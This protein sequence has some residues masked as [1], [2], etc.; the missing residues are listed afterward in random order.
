MTYI[1]NAI[2]L[3]STLPRDSR[4]G[5]LIAEPDEPA[6][7]GVSLEGRHLHGVR[8]LIVTDDGS[9]YRSSV[10]LAL[11]PRDARQATVLSVPD[12]LSGDFADLLAE[13][14]AQS[15][16]R[17][18]AVYLE[19]N[20][21]ISRPVLEDQHAAR[22]RLIIHRSLRDLLSAVRERRVGEEEVHLVTSEYGPLGKLGMEGRAKQ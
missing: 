7:A 21:I 4:S 15:P 20:R 22:P 6:L 13:I 19:A 8:Y 11:V 9:G 10:E 3:G 14:L 2:S 1:V 18:L 5:R 16:S 17:E 12:E